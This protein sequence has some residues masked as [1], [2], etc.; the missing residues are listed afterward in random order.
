M[1]GIAGIVRLDGGSVD[2]GILERMTHFL[3]FRGP[4]GLGTWSCGLAGL[5]HARFKL[6][7][8]EPPNAQPMTLDGEVW[9][10]A[11]ARIDGRDALVSDLRSKGRDTST[12]ADDAELILHAYAAWKEDCVA[13]LLGDF[14][15]AIW[16][17]RLR[18]LWCA[19]DRFGIRPLY[20]ARA[21][22]SFVFSNTLDCLLLHPGV[23]GRLDEVAIGDFLLFGNYQDRDRTVYEAV[24]RLPPASSLV[25]S[26]DGCRVKRY[27]HLE[28]SD[29]VQGRP[30]AIVDEFLHLVE[31]ATCDRIRTGETAV[32]M[33]GGLDSTTVAAA[34]LR[35]PAAI[36][37]AWRLRAYTEDF[38]EWFAHEEP[39][40]AELAARALGI[41]VR[42]QPA[43][44]YVPFDWVERSAWPPPEPAVEPG[45][46]TFQSTLR[47]VAQR[48]RTVMTGFHGD[49]LAA[50]SFAEYWRYLVKGGRWLQLGRELIDY[51]W[52]MRR[53]PPIGIRRAMARRRKKARGIPPWIRPGFARRAGLGDRLG[54]ALERETGER[55]DEGHGFRSLAPLLS[56][57]FFDVFN[58]GWTGCALETSYP[59][60]DARLVEFFQRL[61]PLPWC[62]DKAIF[63]CAATGILPREIVERPKTPLPEFPVLVALR[64]FG[65]HPEARDALRG[66]A[67]EY[68]DP[69]IVPHMEAV[70]YRGHVWTDLRPVSLACWLKRNDEVGTN[71][72]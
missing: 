54:L 60:M 56:L 8:D 23:A 17:G 66:R 50:V 41:D 38:G 53:A 9:I 20:Y 1:S 25:L 5:G 21:G 58:P 65:I 28:P 49:V 45:W 57:S 39:G 22:E 59:L 62:L 2:R 33:S 55:L 43:T 51:T 52:R 11:D 4:D 71:G 72:D 35:S 31:T 69:A 47:E 67:A 7:D 3:S 64:R 36:D 18:R 37:G 40:Y 26:R 68:V 10:A 13:H 16:D 6:S 30:E 46:S 34:A 61:P 29:P 12:G 14:A 63:R 42:R 70:D 48:S 15:F 19:I 44:T 32:F 24:K 27:W